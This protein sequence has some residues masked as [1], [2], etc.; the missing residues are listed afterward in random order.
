MKTMRTVMCLSI[1]VV[2]CGSSGD[3]NS[4][5]PSTATPSPTR[6]PT[7]AP[8]NTATQTQTPTSTP[9]LPP[10]LTPS[11]TDTPTITPRATCTVPPSPTRTDGRVPTATSTPTPS[12]T[13]FPQLA[14]CDMTARGQGCR[15]LR[16][17]EVLQCFMSGFSVVLEHSCDTAL[18]QCIPFPSP[19]PTGTPECLANSH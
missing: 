9:T 5:T 7:L 2:G 19:T 17:A 10:T 15:D 3:G 12:P 16:G 8:T 6:T 4:V 11:P 13:E 14:C 18:E 1:L